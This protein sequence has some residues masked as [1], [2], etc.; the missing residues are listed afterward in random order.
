M[1]QASAHASAQSGAILRLLD[2]PLSDAELAANAEWASR[3]SALRSVR[4]LG[5]LLFRLD[6]ETLALSARMLR[7]VTPYARTRPIPH[8]SGT[9]LRGL[10]NVR[11]E[12]V[13][14][15]D[16]RAL[17]GMP[18]RAAEH[19]SKNDARRMIVIGPADNTWAFEVDALVG[20][21][22]IDEAALRPP[23]VTVKYAMADFTV[24]V[25]DI[26]ERPVTLLNGERILAG[27]GKGL[28]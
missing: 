11:G 6:E 27:F 25:T 7:R 22:R 20:I 17:L 3:E 19:D 10:C 28:A 2:R 24:G 9:I 18:S 1:S 23:P 15:A 14:C 12:L 5:I 8:V 21:E 4:T 13:L 16:L 26:G